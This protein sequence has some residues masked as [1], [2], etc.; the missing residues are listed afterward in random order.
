MLC[1]IFIFCNVYYINS[2]INKC[3]L[4]T[5][6]KIHFEDCR[7]AFLI[8]ATSSKI[9][10]EDKS[11]LL[12]HTTMVAYN[13]YFLR[14]VRNMTK[15]KYRFHQKR[16]MQVL[17]QE[18]EQNQ[19]KPKLERQITYFCRLCRQYDIKTRKA[20][21]QSSVFFK[22]SKIG[23]ILNDYFDSMKITSTRS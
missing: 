1:K 14:C 3:G 8:R 15:L 18:Y 13:I 7:I 4:M 12:D 21:L 23:L 16:T 2:V 17:H 19:A 5:N 9:Q 20:H 6:S 11:K 22:K 10:Q